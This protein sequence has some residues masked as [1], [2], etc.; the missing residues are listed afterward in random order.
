VNSTRTARPPLWLAAAA[1][2]LALWLAL[3]YLP[4]FFAGFPHTIDALDFALYYVGAQ[5]GLHDGWAH[6]YDLAR[7]QAFF[8]LV[9]PGDAFDWRRY[10]VSPPPVA[11]LVAPL[12]ALPLDAAYWAWTV[13]SAA[14]FLA[15]GWVSAPGRGLARAVLMVAGAGLYPVLLAVQSGNVALLVAAAVL[16]GWW[17]LRGGHPVWA[18]VALALLALQQQVAGLVPPTLLLVG[19]RRTFVACAAAAA[20]L[21]L[22]SLATLGGDGLTQLRADLA[23]ESGRSANLLWTLQLLAPPV[24]ALALQ[25]VSAALALGAA[26]RAR[27]HP[28][29]VELAIAA[30]VAGTL[31]AAP[32]HNASDFAA[33]VP[34]TW[35]LLRAGAG[36]RLAWAWAGF[37]FLACY[38]AAPLGPWPILVYTVGLLGLCYRPGVGE[39]VAT[40]TRAGATER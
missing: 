17:L 6:L 11:W 8:V 40:T 18:G 37:G 27:H 10:F 2:L 4:L 39:G 34:A 28:R 20:A 31:L 33:L 32:Y 5:V 38:A 21:A 36:A 29:A 14:A 26:W 24:V 1:L 35:L 23:Q 16:L 30:G 9:R 15:L 12:T 7:Q 22:V 19:Q 13:A 25:L 3:F